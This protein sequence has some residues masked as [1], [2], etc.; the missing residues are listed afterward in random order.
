MNTISPTM[1]RCIEKCLACY[2]ICLRAPVDTSDITFDKAHLTLMLTCAEMCRTCAHFMILG[3]VHHKHTC[4]EC[5]EICAECALVFEG[6]NG[7]QAC[8]DACRECAQE[9]TMM[10]A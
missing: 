10:A 4:R 7:M 8:V 2:A 3:T 6:M 5:A 1:A 9:C